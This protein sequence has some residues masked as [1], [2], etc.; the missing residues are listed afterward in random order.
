MAGETKFTEEEVKSL[1]E[2]QDSYMKVQ[3]KLGRLSIAKLNFQRQAEDLDRQ[4]SEAK[5][6]F[7]NLQT[8]EQELVQELTKKYGQG[9]L[10]PTTGV[11]TPLANDSKDK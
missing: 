3:N 1:K 9:T 10:D 4:D 6:E 11:F 2:L 8:Q 7:V 5:N